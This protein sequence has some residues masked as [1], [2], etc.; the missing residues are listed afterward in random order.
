MKFK[1]MFN[2][3]MQQ[4]YSDR[5]RTDKNHP[6]QN[7]PGKRPLTKPPGQ[8]PQLKQNFYKGAFVRVFCTRP[9]RNREGP[10]CVTYFRGGVPG[11][12]TKGDREEGA[13]LLPLLLLLL[14]TVSSL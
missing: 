11:C 9:Y 4:M 14:F 6:G 10:R 13:R 2:F 3:L 7:L 8:K 1:V 5:T 12:V